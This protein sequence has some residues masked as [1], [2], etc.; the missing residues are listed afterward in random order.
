[1]FEEFARAYI[2]EALRDLGRARRAF[3]EGDYPG[4]VFFAQQAAEK[5]VKAMLEARRRV[6]YNHGPELVAVFAESFEGEWRPEYD[7]VV[8]ALEYLSEYYTRAR[9]PTLFRGRVY[10]P[11]ELVDEEVA[12]RG[13]KLAEEAVGAAREFLRREGIIGGEEDPGREA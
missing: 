6:V 12:R 11:E 1:V 7:K 10:S 2:R 3:R 9:Y 4:A 13:I 5:A 8:E